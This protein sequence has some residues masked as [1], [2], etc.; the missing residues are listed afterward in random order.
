[1]LFP[2]TFRLSAPGLSNPFIRTATPSPGPGPSTPAHHHPPT[3]VDID[4]SQK[5]MITR[6]S[7][8]PP[9]STSRK[10][11]RA[12]EPT[13]AEPSQS[14]VELSLASTNGYLDTPAK[15]RDRDMDMDMA[16][17]T[18]SHQQRAM[19][20]QFHEVAMFS[21]TGSCSSCFGFCVHSTSYTRYRVF[22][23]WRFGFYIAP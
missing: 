18:T 3:R 11:S 7:D 20:D 14:T 5:R 22:C 6:P 15:Y 21:D 9:I 16:S 1:M 10:R 23:V 12:W 13:F 8:S 4:S 17:P 2:F 19:A